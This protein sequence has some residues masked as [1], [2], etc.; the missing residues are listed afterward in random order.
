MKNI[1]KTATV[2]LML[3]ITI[4]GCTKSDDCGGKTTWTRTILYS[5]FFTDSSLINA[6]SYLPG[7]TTY[8]YFY[9]TS[10]H[11]CVNNDPQVI[12]K[13]LLTIRNSHLSNPFTIDGTVG[14][15]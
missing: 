6:N 15:C 11:L 2:L 13:L 5:Q 10:P 8:Y 3:T 1:I 4:A 7:S 9:E 14:T 12:L